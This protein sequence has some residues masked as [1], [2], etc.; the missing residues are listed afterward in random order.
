MKEHIKDYVLHFVTDM[1]QN[2]YEIRKKSGVTNSNIYLSALEREGKIKSTSRKVPYTNKMW[3]REDYMPND[4]VPMRITPIEAVFKVISHEPQS[5]KEIAE[6]SGVKNIYYLLSKLLDD[7][8]VQRKFARTPYAN[9]LMALY[10]LP[11]QEENDAE[12]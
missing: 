10:F 8:L 9:Q 6:K 11:P 3:Y 7:S 2:A 12:S 4:S 5:V 1:P